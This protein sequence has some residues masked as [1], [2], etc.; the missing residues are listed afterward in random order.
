VLADLVGVDHLA[1]LDPDGIGPGQDASL[2]AGGDLREEGL[3][4]GQEF[5]ALAGA[6]GG[7]QGVAAGDQPLAGVVGVGDLGQVVLVEQRQLQRAF[8]QQFADRR[9][10]QRG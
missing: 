6:V 3:G 2:H 9:G 10:A 5:A 1:D 7:Q 8:A 4:G